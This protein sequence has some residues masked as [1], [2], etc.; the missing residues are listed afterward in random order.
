M[1]VPGDQFLLL[2]YTK[3]VSLLPDSQVVGGG[4]AEVIS[5]Q[6]WHQDPDISCRQT[7]DVMSM[8]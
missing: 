1:T 6:R 2:Q 4:R 5:L 8:E 7:H 3:S